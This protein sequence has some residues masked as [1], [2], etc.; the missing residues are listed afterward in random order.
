[1]QDILLIQNPREFLDNGLS[2]S[3][4]EYDMQNMIQAMS[5]GFLTQA[6]IFQDT[7]DV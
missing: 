3:F 5:K 4:L 2:F 6:G 7:P 1:M